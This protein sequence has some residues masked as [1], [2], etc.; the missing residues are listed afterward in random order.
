MAVGDLAA[1][2]RGASAKAIETLLVSAGPPRW[3]RFEDADGGVERHD[4]QEPGDEDLLNRA[5][6]LAAR[7]GARVY[8]VD[9]EKLPD[10]SPVAATLRFPLNL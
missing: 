4:E 9:P 2:L 7:G 5:A 10:E 1:V 3:G 8:A 6:V